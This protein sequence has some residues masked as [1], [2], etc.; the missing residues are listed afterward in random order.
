M[1]DTRAKVIDA[2]DEMV[3]IMERRKLQSGSQIRAVFQLRVGRQSVGNVTIL[4]EPNGRQQGFQFALIRQRMAAAGTA[5]HEIVPHLQ[6]AIA[7]DDLAVLVAKRFDAGAAV[8]VEPFVPDCFVVSIPGRRYPQIEVRQRVS[9]FHFVGELDIVAVIP[10]PS[11]GEADPMD[12]RQG[13]PPHHEINR[14]R[15]SF[16][17]GIGGIKGARTSTDDNDIA[18]DQSIDGKIAHGVGVNLRWKI[19]PDQL[20]KPL[21]AGALNSGAQ[22][23]EL[24]AHDTLGGFQFEAPHIGPPGNV[25]NVD[26]IFDRKFKN[27]A[28]PVEILRPHQTRN[29]LDAAK[30]IFAKF[31]IAPALEMKIGETPVQPSRLA[32]ARAQQVVSRVVSPRSLESGRITVEYFYVAQC[33]TI[34][35]ERDR[36][37]G[38]SR[39][40]HGYFEHALLRLVRERIDRIAK[41][42]DIDADLRLQIVQTPLPADTRE[43]PVKPFRH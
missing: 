6:T 36:L 10:V 41:H 24:R 14:T 40:D 26:V 34:E 16:H 1:R 35:T 12:W 31:Q 20:R 8:D 9:P 3:A 4:P 22:N 39:T 18:T 42:L 2:A 17:S 5:N 7:A 21:H 32:L 23:N 30:I 27:F 25:G 11:A 33:K 15:S 38:L 29:F 13:F 43:R 19:I 37:S 28:K